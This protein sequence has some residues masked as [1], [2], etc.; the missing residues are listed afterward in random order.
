VVVGEGKHAGAEG[1]RRAR[2][3]QVRDEGEAGSDRLGR[4]HEVFADEGLAVAKAIGE[5]D[6]FAVL[7]EH[8]RIGAER[9]VDGLA[10]ES[11]LQRVPHSGSP[12]R[13]ASPEG[14]DKH[15]APASLADGGLGT[16]LCQALVGAV[17]PDDDDYD[18]SLVSRTTS[19]G[20]AR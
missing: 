5:H 16:E 18:A 13:S 20:R 7:A 11:E 17:L 14:A 8:V 15:Q 6:P 1:D 2:V 10:E 12:C 3:G 4:V 9:W 19:H